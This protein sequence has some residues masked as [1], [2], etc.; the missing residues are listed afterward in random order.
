MAAVAIPETLA[1]E[2]K[3]RGID[4]ESWIV[5]M[6]VRALQ[7]DPKTAIA[8]RL[9]L[10]ARYLEEGGSLADRDPVQAS[11]KLYKAAEEAV[12]A[13]AA[14]L[15][16]DAASRAEERGRWTAA[17]LDRAARDA[18][19]RLGG[20]LLDAWDHAWALH[21]WGFHEAKLDADAVR[22]REPYVARL[23]E[24]ARRVCAPG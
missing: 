1:R 19:R 23:V 18:A 11:E 3:K 17:E 8:A 14:C 20:W 10:A 13:L 5:D 7:L 22:E 15:N 2:L 21:V 12:K 4:V 24:E 9:E 16:L 6:I